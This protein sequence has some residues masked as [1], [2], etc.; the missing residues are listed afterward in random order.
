MARKV[1]ISKEII[2]QAALAMLIRDGYSSINIKTLAAE[3][4]CSTQPIVWH[5]DN[6]EG[7]RKA[8][9][10]YAITYARDKMR[11]A[12]G[13]AVEVFEHSGRAYVEMAVNEPNLFRFLYLGENTSE[14]TNNFG[15]ITTSK[16]NAEQ[17]KS[18][19]GYLGISEEKISRYL[20]NTIIYTHGV[21][22]L[23]AT[24]VISA[25]VEEMMEM[26]NRA[27]EGFLMQEGVP[28]DKMPKK[29]EEKRCFQ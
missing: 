3:I 24:N 8:L 15:A 18:I 11:A 4:G 14:T 16:N 23:V 2:L 28:A 7:L 6:M 25:T 20:Q 26:I 21:A 12:S 19:A 1:T 9:A 13:H 5:F 10:A 27:A 17:I 22:T 29:E